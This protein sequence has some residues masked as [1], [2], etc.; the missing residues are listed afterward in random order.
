MQNA[1]VIKVN[2]KLMD[3]KESHRIQKILTLFELKII[4][5]SN[6]QAKICFIERKK[7]LYCLTPLYTNLRL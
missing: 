3:Y 6:V 5:W 2:I 4:S 1:Y 7:D